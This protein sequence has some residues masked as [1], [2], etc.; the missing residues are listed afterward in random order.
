MTEQDYRQDKKLSGKTDKQADQYKDT[1]TDFP[2]NPNWLK[3]IIGKTRHCQ[4][5]LINKLINKITISQISTQIRIDWR[6]LYAKQDTVWEDWLSGWSIR[7]QQDRIPKK[8]KFTEDNYRKDKTLP[9]E[10]D[11][12]T[13]DK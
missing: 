7:C 5:K 12:D 6:T 1:Q 3:K 2:E 9:R 10:T 8:S 13:E 4:E 11:N